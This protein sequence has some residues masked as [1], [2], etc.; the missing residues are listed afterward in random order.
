MT[1]PNEE[2]AEKLTQLEFA[3]EAK[4]RAARYEA[5]LKREIARMQKEA[6]NA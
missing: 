5:Q 4:D 2:L 1:D 3:Q 6:G